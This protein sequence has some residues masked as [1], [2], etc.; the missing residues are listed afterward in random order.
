MLE[1][2][3]NVRKTTQQKVVA[4]LALVLALLMILPMIA[5]IFAI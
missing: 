5:N 4:A 2:G 1:R 3:K